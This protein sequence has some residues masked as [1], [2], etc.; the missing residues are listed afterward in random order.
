MER[1][2][3]G[4]TKYMIFNTV[5]LGNNHLESVDRSEFGDCILEHFS[6]LK[7]LPCRLFY[8]KRTLLWHK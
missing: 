3:S 2:T 8:P 5:E 6:N 4:I 1:Y 7:I